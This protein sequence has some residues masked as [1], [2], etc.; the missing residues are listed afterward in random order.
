MQNP[1]DGMQQIAEALQCGPADA[2]ALMSGYYLYCDAGGG[3][4]HGFIVVAGYL[5]TFG[6]WSA[7]TAQWNELLAAFDIP[8]FHMKKFSQFKA[9]FDGEKW[10]D[11][12][13]RARFLSSAANIIANHVEKSISSVVEFETFDRVNRIYRLDDAV[14]VPYSLAG[15]T[16]AAKASMHRGTSTDATYIFDDGDEGRGELMRVMERDGYPSPIFRPSRDQQKN[17]RPVKGLVPLQ[18]A[19]FAAYEL[20]KVYRDDPNELWPL[21]KYRKSIR[22]LSVVDTE[23]NKYTEQDLIKL[24][25]NVPRIAKKR[26]A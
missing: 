21:E 26:I 23:W 8:Y 19:D 20:R 1:V 10:K 15:R 5:S 6:R 4:D 16:C 17:G 7:F 9:P 12:G 2:A 25:E 11:E 22:A 13:R 18:A 3:K 24:C 14:G